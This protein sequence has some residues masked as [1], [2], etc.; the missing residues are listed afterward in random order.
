M[1][2]T[3]RQRKGRAPAPIVSRDNVTPVTWPACQ[4]RVGGLRVRGSGV[5][6][7]R[8]QWGWGGGPAR[9]QRLRCRRDS[10]R[11]SRLRRARPKNDPF[12]LSKQEEAPINCTH[13][14]LVEE[15]DDLAVE[16]LFAL[17]LLFF[18]VHGARWQN[19][20]IPG[21]QVGVQFHGECCLCKRGKTI[22]QCTW[23][24]VGA[25]NMLHDGFLR[26][27][28]CLAARS[29]VW[30]FGPHTHSDRFIARANYKYVYSDAITC[31]V[32]SIGRKVHQSQFEF[33]QF[34]ITYCPHPM[35]CTI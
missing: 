13:F 27:V 5:R 30:R 16:R 18:R 14:S 34:N 15:V 31:T 20:L 12:S 3:L 23:G 6:G 10:I 11:L 19:G 17:P 9:W 21:Q 24:F 25:Q 28:W 1:K 29:A 22:F 7:V 33:A 2:N 4:V 26:M 32:C 8:D 35:P